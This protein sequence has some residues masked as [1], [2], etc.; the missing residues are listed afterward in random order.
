MCGIIGICMYASNQIEQIW[1]CDKNFPLKINNFIA[2]CNYGG[3]QLYDNY[4]IEQLIPKSSFKSNT[5]WVRMYS[6]TFPELIYNS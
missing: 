5:G 3:I 1:R 4:L 2:N 6:I